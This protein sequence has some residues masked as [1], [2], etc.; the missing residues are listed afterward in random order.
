MQLYALV[1]FVLGTGAPAGVPPVCN[2]TLQDATQRAAQL[3][4]D[5]RIEAARPGAAANS[6][7]GVVALQQRVPQCP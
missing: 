7:Y 1:F 5:A 3:I 2:L 4:T 6:V